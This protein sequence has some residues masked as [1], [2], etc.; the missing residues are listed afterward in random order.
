MISV[1]TKNEDLQQDL[2][3][4]YLSNEI[5]STFS[6]KLKTLALSHDIQKTI[7][8]NYQKILDL[9]I[10]EKS[11]SELSDF[12]KSILLLTI[13]G[14]TLEQ[15]SRYNGVKQVIIDQEMVDLTKH[16]L[17]KKYGLKAQPKSRRKIRA[18]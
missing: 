13:L 17:W 16:H 15:V 10:D 18:H 6:E 4:A 5:D 1:L 9:D 11:L 12:Q 8:D 2:W 14:Y 3:V 7:S